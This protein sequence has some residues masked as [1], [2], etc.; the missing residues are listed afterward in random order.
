MAC[1]Y[2][3]PE[4]R[5][6]AELWPHRHRLPLADGFS[7][8][9]TAPGHEGH[10]PSD[11]EL[12]DFCNIGYCAACAHL[13]AN[14]EADAVRFA[15]TG[16]SGETLSLSWVTERSYLPVAHGKLEYDARSA[17]WLVSHATACIQRMAECFMESYLSRHP[18]RAVPA[19]AKS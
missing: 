5:S 7:G 10:R 1:P 18:R 6:D 11:S 17:Q 14:R 19:S 16:E 13:P 2:F 15:V 3:F 8:H 4:Q 9:C 12:K